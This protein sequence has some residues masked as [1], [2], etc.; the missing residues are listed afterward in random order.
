MTQKNIKK[1][2]EKL[3][4]LAFLLV[5]FLGIVSILSVLVIMSNSDLMY[6]L[7]NENDSYI[8]SQNN[9]IPLTIVKSNNDTVEISVEVADTPAS[10]EI[11]LM[12]RTYLALNKGMLFVFDTEEIRSFWMKNTYIPLDIIFLN[13]DKKI[14]KIH[15]NTTPLNTT[16]RYSSDLPAKYCIEVNGGWTDLNNIEVGNQVFF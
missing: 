3:K 5:P 4:P 12:D 6:K 8:S 10:R 13:Q 15:K 1:I 11:G 9:T 16:L 14:I 7:V 2:L